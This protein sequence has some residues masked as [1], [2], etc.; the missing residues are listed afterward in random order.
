MGGLR[1]ACLSRL[2]RTADQDE[3]V[4]RVRMERGG[5]EVE[6]KTNLVGLLEGGDELAV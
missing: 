6:V 3:K 4:W 2:S 1:H 5:K